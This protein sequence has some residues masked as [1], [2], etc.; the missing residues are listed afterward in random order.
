MD[1]RMQ[2]LKSHPKLC[3]FNSLS[4]MYSEKKPTSKRIIK[5]FNVEP[6]SD[7]KRACFD[8]FKRYTKSLNENMLAAHWLQF[9]TGSDII[10]VEKIELSFN[11]TDGIAR[12]IVV[13]TCGPTIELPSTYRTYNE[14]SE[15]LTNTLKN[16]FA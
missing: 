9:L 6:K 3:D 10:T 16:S 5:L 14:F 2:S 13:H 15:E 7:S 12:G 4:L 8:H 1:C 11:A